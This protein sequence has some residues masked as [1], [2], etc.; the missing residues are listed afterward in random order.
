MTPQCDPRF[1]HIAGR[2]LAP[3]PR[4]TEDASFGGVFVSS[5]RYAGSS[6]HPAPM[7]DD[8]VCRMHR[9][10]DGRIAAIA[11]ASVAAAV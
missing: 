10:G 8:V 2:R 5:Q 6:V 3:P 4:D 11:E 1:F 7:D 9:Q